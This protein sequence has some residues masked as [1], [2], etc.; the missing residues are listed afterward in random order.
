MNT[1]RSLGVVVGA[2]CLLLAACGNERSATATR[3]TMEETGAAFSEE[4]IP[5]REVEAPIDAAT[6]AGY[7]LVAGDLDAYEKGVSFEN[8]RLREAIGHGGAEGMTA[9]VAALPEQTEPAAAAETGLDV[10]R[11]RSVKSAVV[12]VLDR[13]ALKGRQSA[14]SAPADDAAVHES[15]AEM[16]AAF[17]DPYAGL[18]GAVKQDFAARIARLRRLR[19]ENVALLE[20]AGG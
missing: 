18:D 17:D 6:F 15:V 11:Y 1:N 19:D 2:A 20:Q 13:V 16:Q 12:D 14:S 8:A 4:D 10:E 5:T 9:F 3:Q 7:A